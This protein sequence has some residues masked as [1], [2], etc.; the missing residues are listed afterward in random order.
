MISH[1]EMMDTAGEIPRILD[2]EGKIL[3]RELHLVDE[4]C[5]SRC[6]K[7]YH[8]SAVWG[9]LCWNTILSPTSKS[10]LPPPRPLPFTIQSAAE[11]RSEGCCPSRN[12]LYSD[13]WWRWSP[14]ETSLNKFL[15]KGFKKGN[16][17]DSWNNLC[18]IKNNNNNNK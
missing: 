15:K 1:L 4:F 6:M 11:L 10:A 7:I 8:W 17:D 18:P 2:V 5:F 13:R 12:P 14:L 3:R 9:Y 16:Q